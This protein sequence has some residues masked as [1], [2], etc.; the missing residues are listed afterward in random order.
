VL[1]DEDKSDNLI[2]MSKT[3]TATEVSR[4]FSDVLDL[5]EN[6]E[7][8]FITRGKKVI[9]KFEKVRKVIAKFEKVRSETSGKRLADLLSGASDPD[10][11]PQIGLLWEAVMSARDSEEENRDRY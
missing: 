6:G 5:V 2:F 4:S 1:I 9:A 10:K 11:D 7:T 8:V 3:M